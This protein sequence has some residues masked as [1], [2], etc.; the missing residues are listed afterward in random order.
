MLSKMIF[1]ARSSRVWVVTAA[2]RI[3]LKAE[4]TGIML[5]FSFDSL[6]LSILQFFESGVAFP[7]ERQ[8]A[9]VRCFITV[10]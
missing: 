10:H 3:A 8:V 1:V 4:T 7:A 5:Y 9:L 6:Y 2:S